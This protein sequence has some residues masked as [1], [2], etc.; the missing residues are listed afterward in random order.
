[1]LFFAGAPE[2]ATLPATINDLFWRTEITLTS[3][4]ASAPLACKT[5]L[6][7]IKER[8]VPVFKTV[9]HRLALAEGPSGFKNVCAPTEHDCIKVIIEPHMK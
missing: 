6:S 2:G 4:Y 1:M 9:T 7:L 3:S 8:A 5:A